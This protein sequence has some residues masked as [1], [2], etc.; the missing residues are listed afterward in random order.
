MEGSHARQ[1]PAAVLG[2]WRE[3]L[4]QHV[5]P[6][7]D[8]KKLAETIVSAIEIAEGED[9]AE[10]SKRWGGSAAIVHEAVKHLPKGRG[11]KLLGAP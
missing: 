10:S 6:L 7:A 1:F 11:P 5:I 2:S 3:L 4:G 9:A 8:H